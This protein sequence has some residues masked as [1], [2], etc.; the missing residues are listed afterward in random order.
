MILST[1]FGLRMPYSWSMEDLEIDTSLLQEKSVKQTDVW[2]C[3]AD[4]VGGVIAWNRAAESGSGFGRNDFSTISELMQLLIPDESR[5]REV[6]AVFTGGYPEAQGT[7]RIEAEV[8]IRSGLTRRMVWQ[9]DFLQDSVNSRRLLIATGIDITRRQI[10]KTRF[11][12]GEA[13]HRILLENLQE[14]IWWVNEE[15]RTL[16]ANSSL[17]RILGIRSTDLLGKPLTDFFPEGNRILVDR[18]S[19]EIK[20]H[21]KAGASACVRIS[22]GPLAPEVQGLG[23]A[24]MSVIDLTAE[25]RAGEEAEL[26]AHAVNHASDGIVITDAAGRIRYVNSAFSTLTGYSKD[27]ALGKPLGLLECAEDEGKSCEELWAGISSGEGWKG[28]VRN[29]RKDG[30]SYSEEESG[31]IVRDAS[32]VI[33]GY[34]GVKRDVTRELKIKEYLQTNQKL[35]AVG[36]LAGGIA[37]DFNNILMVILSYTEIASTAAEPDS[38]L[39]LQLEEIRN[40]ARR[41]C[42]LTDQLLLFSR[43]GAGQAGPTDIRSAVGEAVKMLRATTPAAIH[44]TADLS[45]VLPPVLIS[46][47]QIVQVVMNLGLNAVAAIEANDTGLI[48]ISVCTERSDGDKDERIILRV[49]DDGC[50]ME[51]ATVSRI[52]EPF[53]STRPVGVGTGMGL[54]VVHGII[55]GAGGVIDIVSEPGMGSTFSLSLPAYRNDSGATERTGSCESDECIMAKGITHE[56]SSDRR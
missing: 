35:Q 15:G 8:I 37:H 32:G 36:T 26:L 42:D 44:I 30:T 50:G 10:E 16:Y 54:A 28:V 7:N 18:I 6:A 33:T 4:A 31:S 21:T 38:P 23:G 43:G 51:A 25:R 56:Y 49:T 9:V 41:A 55:Q 22:G 40:A 24:L 52:F 47:T 5:R 17:L 20:L 34:I 27:E 11:L 53:F 2:I 13:I 1:Y 39:S 14:G 29:Q 3:V 12:H 19:E 46:A 45:A 48:S